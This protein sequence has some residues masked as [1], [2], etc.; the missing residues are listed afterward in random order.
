MAVAVAAQSPGVGIDVQEIAE[1]ILEIADEF[2][3]D[4]ELERVGACTGFMQLT[5]LTSIWAMKEAS[6]KAAGPEACLMK[7]LILEK[8]KAHG[9]YVVCE[10]YHSNTGHIKSVAFQSNK[11]V[12]AA[13]RLLDKEGTEQPE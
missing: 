9:D 12:Y 3:T 13:S 10:L 8:A 1:S 7:E 2:S 5:A 4:E 11:Y 6:R